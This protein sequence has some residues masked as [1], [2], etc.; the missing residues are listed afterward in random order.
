MSTRS[1]DER[2]DSLVPEPRFGRR[3]RRL[4]EVLVEQGAITSAQLEE[5][6]TIQ[7]DVAPGDRRR[8]LGAVIVEA[9]FA[10]EAQVASALAGALGLDLVDL[11]SIPLA[12]EITR[13][14][15]RSV[16][17]RH[18]L[19][20]LSRTETGGLIVASADPTNVVAL[21]DVR[22]YTKATDITVVVATESQLRER[23][24]RSWSLSEDSSDV[25]TMFEEAD[26]EEADDLGDSTND[27]AP[28][29]R[30]VN[31]ML[32]D[33]VRA[34]ASDIHVEPQAGDMRIR[35]RVDGLLRDVMTV[36]RTAAAGVV[37]RIKV[38]SNLDIAERR[39]PQDGRAR[40]A[41]DGSTIDTRVSTLPNMHGEKVV[42]RLLARADRVARL[43]ELGMDD[44]QLEVLLG[45]LASPQGL[46]LITGPTGS[47]KTNTLY[48]A[49]NEIRSAERNIVTLED[50][51]EIQLPGITQTQVHEKA[52]LTFAKGLRSILRQDPD[53]ILVGEVRDPDTAKLALESALTGHLVLT[54]LHTNNAPAALTRLVDMGVEPFL[55]ASSLALVVAQRLVR[56]VCDMCAEPY[57]PATR[58][59]TVL[60]LTPDDLAG[61][62][63]RKGR[64]CTHC[65]GTGYR[66]RIGV[67][68]TLPV[69]AHLRSVLLNTP[70]EAAVAA[71]VRAAGMT[72]LRGSA[73]SKARA[74]LTTYDEVLRVTHV[75]AA[76]GAHCPTCEH[77][78]AE[79][80]VVCPW[81]GT[82]VNRGH[83]E[84]CARPLEA[85]WILCP[86]CRTPA[87]ERAR[88]AEAAVTQPGGRV[89]VIDD[90]RA[91]R[92][93]L[94]TS[95]SG[96]VGLDVVGT[97]EDALHKLANQR[98]DGVVVNADLADRPGLEVIR[99][100][101]S[102]PVTSKLPLAVL[103]GSASVEQEE[104]ARAAGADDYLV[105]PV[106]A[107]ALE[108]RITALLATSH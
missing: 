80:M 105:T 29:V 27:H 60:G 102:S 106:E 20:P 14:L 57:T 1:A 34:G 78:L 104:R 47:G 53:V 82:P 43:T 22:L 3:R 32:A 6:L 55:V 2:L 31:A 36:P 37:S 26:E 28:V 97:V 92:A 72:T 21:D 74:G 33:A 63:P 40:L 56:R 81:C 16:A 66:G 84:S 52:G 94:T 23:I 71:A 108:E 85:E 68:E 11:G 77:G 50:P 90:D 7:R 48:S 99:L 107:E 96:V 15:P 25:A 79:D 51:V 46:V 86:W 12:S 64:G 83:C 4:G 18:H 62:T 8:R 35:Y 39:V 44:T 101:R 100:L 19:L 103:S 65:A 10:T 88:P 91:T 42:I 89:L 45:T 73:L 70:T 17:Q 59:L 75:D 76:G 95:L 30:L 41:V 58:T 24:S 38:I 5:A 54:T 61:A 9:G 49:I 98:Y 87:S 13:L 67:F 93:Y 69:T